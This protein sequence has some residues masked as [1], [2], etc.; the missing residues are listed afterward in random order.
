MCQNPEITESGT[1]NNFFGVGKFWTS[2]FLESGRYRTLFISGIW[3]TGKF[4][5]KKDE[6]MASMNNIINLGA[7]DTDKLI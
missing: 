3:H 7:M 5:V 1:G 4:G 6:T 2:I